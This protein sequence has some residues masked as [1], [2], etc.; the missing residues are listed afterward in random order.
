MWTI[1]VKPAT[2][3]FMRQ[4]N[5]RTRLVCTRFVALVVSPVGGAPQAADFDD[6]D[7][8]QTTAGR[9]APRPS[10][11]EVK[12]GTGAAN[13]EEVRRLGSGGLPRLHG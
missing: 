12:E 6:C 11:V 10:R 7:R 13:R 3:E 9:L 2:A 4:E 1:V 8:R 5:A